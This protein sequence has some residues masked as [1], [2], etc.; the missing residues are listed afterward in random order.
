[1]TSPLPPFTP[2]KILAATRYVRLHY[3]LVLKSLQPTDQRQADFEKVYER[4][5]EF[6]GKIHSRVDVLEDYTAALNQLPGQS[7]WWACV[8]HPV[9]E[10]LWR[11]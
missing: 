11:K 7:V 5:G 2:A 9:L 3:A 4:I 10:E 1:M 6:Y 8:A